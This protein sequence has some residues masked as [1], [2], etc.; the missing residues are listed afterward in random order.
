MESYPKVVWQ[1]GTAG[2]RTEVSLL[3]SQGSILLLALILLNLAMITE[4]F[5]CFKHPARCCKFK[6]ATK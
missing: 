4:F 6:E 5:V 2:A 3:A 1:Q